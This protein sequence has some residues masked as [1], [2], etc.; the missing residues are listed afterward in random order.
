MA[1]VKRGN[2]AR[3]RRNKILKL[4]KGF[5][6]SHSK[7]FRTANQQVMKAL[8]NAYRDRRKKKRDF[9][10]LWI[11]RINAASRQHGMSYSQLIGN[12]NKANI[13]I[14]RKMLAQMAVLD[15]NSFGKVVEAASQAKG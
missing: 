1:R 15:P 8:R 5:R 4:A 2:V 6:G 11:T 9:R 13:L 14:N 10:R 3:K 12:L 7:L